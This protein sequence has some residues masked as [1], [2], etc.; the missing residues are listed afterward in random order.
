[1]L[2]TNET[3]FKIK[4]NRDSELYFKFLYESVN[5]ALNERFA[6]ESKYHLKF[7]IP[8]K[9]EEMALAVARGMIAKPE[10]VEG[11]YYWGICRNGRVAR[12][13]T[14]LQMFEHNRGQYNRIEQ[15]PHP[16]NEETIYTS[17]KLV[18][19]DIFVPF[20]GVDP[21]GF[22]IIGELK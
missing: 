17:N 14:K 18:G 16:E 19:F 12:W 6:W 2:I 4:M 7:S 22:E 11:Q 20:Y 13:S 5:D 15:I 9:P 3:D 21:Q 10:L 1:M 8:I